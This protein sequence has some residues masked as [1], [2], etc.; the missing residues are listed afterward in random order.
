VAP[1]TI[2]E[3]ELSQQRREDALAELTR[4]IRERR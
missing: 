2:H 4:S 1:P 3:E